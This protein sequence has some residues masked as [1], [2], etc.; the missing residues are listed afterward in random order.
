MKVTRYHR[1]LRGLAGHN[2]RELRDVRDRAS[3]IRRT[4]PVGRE[5]DLPVAGRLWV[6]IIACDH[7]LCDGHPDGRPAWHMTRRQNVARQRLL[8]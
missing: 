6:V 7:L 3:T 1:I 4:H 2:R 8:G 5:W